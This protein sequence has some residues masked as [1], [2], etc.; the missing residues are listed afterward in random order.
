MDPIRGCTSC[1][2]VP[3]SSFTGRT[4]QHTLIV[5]FGSAG[6]LNYVAKDVSNGKQ[7]LSYSA[8]GQMGSSASIKAGAYRAVANGMSAVTSYVGDFNF[9]QQ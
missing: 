4:V 1:A 3:I 5:K 7:L 6:T 2:S 8:K 9:R